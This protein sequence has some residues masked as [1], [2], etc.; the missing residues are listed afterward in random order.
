[1]DSSEY[2]RYMTEKVVSLIDNPQ[3]EQEEHVKKRTPEPWLSRWFGVA[4]MG[5]MMWWGNRRNKKNE[6]HREVRSVDTTSYR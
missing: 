4:P 3:A 6:T 2:L 1:M 5:I